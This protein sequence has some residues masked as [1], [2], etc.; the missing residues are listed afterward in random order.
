MLSW[1]VIVKKMDENIQKALLLSWIWGRYFV[2]KKIS[3]IIP[4]FVFTYSLKPNIWKMEQSTYI[5][6]IFLNIFCIFQ[7]L[8]ISF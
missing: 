8:A 3:W 4:C 2:F 7:E 6:L 5:D 1:M